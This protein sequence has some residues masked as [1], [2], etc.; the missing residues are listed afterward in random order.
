MTNEPRVGCGAAILSG[1]RIL[2]IQR[3]TAPESGCWGL[4]GGKVDLGETAARAVRRE[5]AEELGID[6]VLGDLLCLVEQFDPHWVSPVYR[7][8]VVSGEPKVMEPL[9]HGGAAWF[10]LSALPSPLTQA[11][12]VAA[13]ALGARG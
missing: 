1:D 11:T 5:I 6:I 10:Q 2:L 3:L 12:Q 9:K 13:A 4:P 7:A 8:T